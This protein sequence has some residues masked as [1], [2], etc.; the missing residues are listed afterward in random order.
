MK[1]FYFFILLGLCAFAATAQLVNCR[2]KICLIDYNYHNDGAPNADMT[3][4]KNALPDILIDNTPGGYWNG[5]CNAS[6]YT[7]LGIKVFSYIT[8]GYEGTK[9]HTSEDDLTANLARVDAIAN[10]GA[11]GVFLDEVDYNPDSAAK[12]YI[13]AIYTECQ[14]KG[15]LLIVNPGVNNFASWLMGHCDYILTDENYNG[16]R[17]L[18]PSEALYADRVLVVAQNVTSDANA[19]AITSGASAHGFGYSYACNNYL[20]LAP[21]LDNYLSLATHAPI[22]PTITAA[23]TTLLSDA[24]SG[25]QWYEETMGAM[26]G[27]TNQNYTATADGIYYSIVTLANCP[28]DTSN[29]ITIAGTAVQHINNTQAVELY[30]NPANDIIT[31]RIDGHNATVKVDIYDV[32]G[33]LAVSAAISSTKIAMPVSGLANGTYIAIIEADGRLTRKKLVVNR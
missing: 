13:T 12:A 2:P 5:A 3:A 18:S 28:S 20:S 6:E 15:L 27:A 29:K 23:G 30:P 1:K 19:A 8:S 16:T 14:A 31:I 21:W 26:A 25:N 7:P 9:Y 17:S 33:K 22:T 11:T 4:I 32:V 10:D 24:T